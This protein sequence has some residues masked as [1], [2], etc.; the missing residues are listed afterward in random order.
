MKLINKIRFWIICKLLT[1]DEKWL[2]SE[3]TK[4]TKDKLYTLSITTKILDYYTLQKDIK[5]L[6][7]LYKIFR[8]HEDK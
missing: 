7:T 6:D 3:T 8:K 2:I 4:V 5:E 1:Y